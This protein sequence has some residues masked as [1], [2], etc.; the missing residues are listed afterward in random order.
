MYAKG[1]SIE[2][3]TPITL[4]FSHHNYASR[5]SVHFRLHLSL[6]AGEVA[7]NEWE[8]ACILIL[9]SPCA[10]GPPV[11]SMGYIACVTVKWSSYLCILLQDF[12]IKKLMLN[13]MSGASDFTIFF[14]R[15]NNIGPTMGGSEGTYGRLEILG[16]T[17]SEC[18]LP[19]LAGVV[20][21]FPL[22]WSLHHRSRV[23]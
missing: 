10:V 19:F 16:T 11:D 1:N 9:K 4:H 8:C 2:E 15:P 3:T 21:L 5:V 17:S 7:L 22:G 13:L 14:T 23:R 6:V 12:D 18:A 20:S